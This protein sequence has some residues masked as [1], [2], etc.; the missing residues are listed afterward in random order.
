MDDHN[1]SNFIS[2]LMLSPSDSIKKLDVF[3]QNRKKI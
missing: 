3:V 1:D 2:P